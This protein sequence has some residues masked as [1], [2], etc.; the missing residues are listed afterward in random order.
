MQRRAFSLQADALA[1]LYFPMSCHF[2][3]RAFW[4]LPSKTHNILRKH[5]IT[6]ALHVPLALRVSHPYPVP[7]SISET[8]IIPSYNEEDIAQAAKS[9]SWHHE[10]RGCPVHTRT[11]EPLFKKKKEINPEK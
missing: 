4:N 2:P 1:D 8:L 3:E 6:P 7:N 10:G 11:F 9:T 5:I